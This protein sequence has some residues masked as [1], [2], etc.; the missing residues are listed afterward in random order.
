MG[1]IISNSKIYLDASAT[2]GGAIAASLW[3]QRITSFK[4][5]DAESAEGKKAIGVKGFAGYVRKNGGGT[6]A[7]TE[8]RQDKPQFDW[9]KAKKK[10]QTLQITTQDENGGVREK[11]LRVVVSK[12]DKSLDDEGNHVD[13]IELLYGESV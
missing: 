13:E 6:I 8:L 12:V 9:R 4:V 3:L 10:N 11:F 2:P 5:T 1:E 7:I